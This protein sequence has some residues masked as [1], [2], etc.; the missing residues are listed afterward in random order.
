MIHFHDYYEPKAELPVIQYRSETDLIDRD[1][2]HTGPAWSGV[3]LEV[4]L[5]IHETWRLLGKLNKRLPKLRRRWQISFFAD[6]PLKN[7]IEEVIVIEYGRNRVGVSYT[8]NLTRG[9]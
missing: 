7:T 6:K 9:L 1:L 8:N 2:K 5:R 3:V 4:L